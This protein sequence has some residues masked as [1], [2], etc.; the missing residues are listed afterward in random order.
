MVRPPNRLPFASP[1]VLW[2][3]VFFPMMALASSGKFSILTGLVSVGYVS[4]LP[5]YILG[6]LFYNLSVRRK[7][8]RIWESTFMCQ[9][10]GAVTEP[11]FCIEQPAI[12]ERALEKQ[13]R[14]VA[15]Y[16]RG[17]HELP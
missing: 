17:G 8:Y 12:L 5:A 14:H 6:A 4:L 9:R 11:P 15:S 2:L 1:V 3:V 7:K 10:C 13:G 16:R